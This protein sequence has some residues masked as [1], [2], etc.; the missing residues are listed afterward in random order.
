M[1]RYHVLEF[2]GEGSFAKVYKG[3]RKYS[4]RV[5]NSNFKL[6]IKI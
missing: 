6:K 1:D 5:G 3:R 2:I 4:G